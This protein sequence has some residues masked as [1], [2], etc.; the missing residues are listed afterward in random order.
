MKRTSLLFVGIPFLVSA[1]G[2]DAPPAPQPS[3]PPPRPVAA[4]GPVSGAPSLHPLPAV[5]DPTV[6]PAEVQ[7][8]LRQA[9]AD[10]VAAFV[11]GRKSQD[12]QCAQL[13]AKQK[14]AHD[15][16]VADFET[17]KKKAKEAAEANHKDAK[18]KW[19]EMQAKYAAILADPNASPA[20]K[21]DARVRASVAFEP[22]TFDAAS[23]IGISPPA[24]PLPPVPPNGE[25][26]SNQSFD[27]LIFAF[28]RAVGAHDHAKAGQIMAQVAKLAPK[29]SPGLMEIFQ[30]D[31]KKYLASFPAKTPAA[32]SSPPQP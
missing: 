21:E 20:D 18:A 19:D 5:A 22:P 29:V 11:Q 14:A 23:A 32:A 10:V 2:K 24:P 25:L 7:V 16:A 17:A 4:S 3:A 30:E 12:E 31:A 9:Y 26:Q 15:K 6:P 1:C 27:D 13:Q 8:A 28:R